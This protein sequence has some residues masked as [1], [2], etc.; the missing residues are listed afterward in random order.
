MQVLLLLCLAGVA[1]A[2]PQNPYAF[3]YGVAYDYS[4]ANYEKA[5]NQDASGNLQGSY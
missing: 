2:L 1:M 4:G 5:E 3:Q